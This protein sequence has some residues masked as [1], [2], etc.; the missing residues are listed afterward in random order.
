MKSRIEN[1]KETV[2]DA[3]PDTGK[4]VVPFV[5]NWKDVHESYCT[6]NFD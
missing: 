2:C 4:F 3:M 5:F 1:F 6:D